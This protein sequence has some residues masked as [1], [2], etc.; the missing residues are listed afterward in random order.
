LVVRN[1]SFVLSVASTR[2]GHTNRVFRNVAQQ[3][4]IGGG[5]ARATLPSAF[6]A[7]NVVSGAGDSGIFV[8]AGARNTVLWHNT[9]TDN[10]HD[11]MQQD[12]IYNGSTSTVFVGNVANNKN[13]G[14][15]SVP[16]VIDGGENRASG[17]GNPAQCINVSCVDD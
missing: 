7:D 13:L 12:G 16:G 15:E 5:D 10:G 6:V 11:T 1:R 9:A 3:M 4:I 2:G 14:I 8:D 17:N